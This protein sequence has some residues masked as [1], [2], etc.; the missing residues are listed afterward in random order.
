MITRIASQL[1][2][3]RTSEVA[4]I[5]AEHG[6]L[7]LDRR[8]FL[9]LS[10]GSVALLGAA[11][12][13]GSE[14]S[15]GAAP[16]GGKAD[17]LVFDE[18]GV[19]LSGVTGDDALG[20]YW[21]SSIQQTTQLAGPDQP[22]QRL[23]VMG[24]VFARD[25]I[26][27][28]GGAQVA[29]WQ[30]DDDGLYDFNHAGLNQ[31]SSQGELTAGQTR[32]RGWFTTSATGT[33]SFESI[34]PSEYPLNLLDPANSAFRAPHIHFAVFWTD[35]LGTRHQ[36]VTQMYFAVNDLILGIVPDLDALNAGDG[37]ASAA[38]SS[39]FVAL[40]ANRT[41]WHGEFDIVLDVDPALVA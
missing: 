28:I 8:G 14:A 25:C 3:P 10:A 39:R 26:T 22:G 27:P 36:L 38:E 34:V 4:A 5:E 18:N 2:R 16:G 15:G 17:N 35:R 33:Y 6:R 40:E 1:F 12:C 20:P 24:S 9:R 7:A 13:V 30:A 29:A 41:M 23:V 11:G 21:T 19:C 37:G 32:L 31:G